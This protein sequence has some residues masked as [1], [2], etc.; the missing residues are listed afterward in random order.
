M[1]DLEQILNG[2]QP[3]PVV[4]TTAQQPEQEPEQE[5]EAQATGEPEPEPDAQPEPEPPEPQMVPIS[6]VQGLREE[7]RRLKAGQSQ[8]ESKPAPSFYDDPEGAMQ[9][10]MQPVQNM[11]INQ[12][13]EMSRFSAE[14]EFGKDVVDAAFEYFNQHPEQSAQLLDH[15]SPFHAAVDAYNRQKVTSEIGDDPEAWKAQEREKIRAELQAEQVAEQA[16]A[17]AAQTAPSMAHETGVGGGAKTTWS[18]PTS[19]DDIL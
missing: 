9:H 6:V 5:P 12:K 8:P 16:R 17:K 14:R 18:G 10:Q 15:P 4:E 1:S 13:L 19:L 2:E 3:D 7:N 11:V